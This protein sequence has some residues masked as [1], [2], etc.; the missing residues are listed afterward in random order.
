MK[1]AVTPCLTH[2]D[3]IISLSMSLEGPTFLISKKFMT[4]SKAGRQKAFSF[5]TLIL[6][7]RYTSTPKMRNNNCNRIM[8]TKMPMKKAFGS[9][10]KGMT[11]C[12]MEK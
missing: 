3:A 11:A 4:L 2:Q 8:I 1:G 12:G 5:D 7:H 6:S 9:A 10:G